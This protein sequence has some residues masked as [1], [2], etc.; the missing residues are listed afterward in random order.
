ML[1]KETIIVHGL[2][3][4]LAPGRDSECR[5]PVELIIPHWPV[6]SMRAGLV[7]DAPSK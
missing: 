2:L 4:D 5:K 6:S 3:D 1:K 7:T